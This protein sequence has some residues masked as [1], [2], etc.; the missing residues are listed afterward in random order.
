MVYTKLISYLFI[1]TEQLDTSAPQ[2]VR[3]G[4]DRHVCSSRSGL[5]LFCQVWNAR[6]G[7]RHLRRK[8]VDRID[9]PLREKEKSIDRQIFPQEK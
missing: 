7:G 8:G 3:T 9:T 6:C 1:S 5:R 4:L 2:G